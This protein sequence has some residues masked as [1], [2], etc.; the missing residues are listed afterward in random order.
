MD[1]VCSLSHRPQSAG[2]EIRP[3]FLRILA[4]RMAKRMGEG[5]RTEWGRLLASPTLLMALYGEQGE[6]SYHGASEPPPPAL[7]GDPK[8]RSCRGPQPGQGCSCGR[9]LLGKP[10]LAAGQKY[11]F[12]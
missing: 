10:S 6:G 5:D 1:A 12:L 3:I 7:W 2:S 8:S 11:R 4:K 9:Q